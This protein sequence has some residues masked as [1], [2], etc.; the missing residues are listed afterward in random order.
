MQVTGHINLAPKFSDTLSTGL[1]IDQENGLPLNE[2]TIAKR[3]KDL[4][5]E[6]YGYGKWQ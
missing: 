5:Y 4:G 2:T 6:T 1:G 3:L